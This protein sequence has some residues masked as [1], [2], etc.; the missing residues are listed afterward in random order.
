MARPKNAE[1]PLMNLGAQQ[2]R[3]QIPSGEKA[4]QIFIVKPG[5]NDEV[6]RELAELLLKEKPE[7]FREPT[8]TEIAKGAGDDDDPDDGDADGGDGK[9]P[10]EA[11]EG[12]KADKPTAT[13]AAGAGTDTG[14]G[15]TTPP[16]RRS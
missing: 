6:P 10:G 13:G 11:G 4:G 16:V 1:I 2:H 3:A 8:R 12:K 9:D 14:R 15:V 5:L 7:L